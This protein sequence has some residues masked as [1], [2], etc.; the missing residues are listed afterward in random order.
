MLPFILAAKARGNSPEEIIALIVFLAIA[1]LILLL[2]NFN[3][4]V[5][6]VIKNGL[7]HCPLCGRQ[8]SL[9]RDNCRACGYQI[10]TYGKAAAERKRPV[11]ASS[12]LSAN[13]VSDWERLHQDPNDYSA[14]SGLEQAIERE[15]GERLMGPK[16][17]DRDLI[18]HKIILR[19]SRLQYEAHVELYVGHDRHG[20]IITVPT[21]NMRI[22][23]TCPRVVPANVV[24]APW[25]ELLENL[26]KT[27]RWVIKQRNSKSSPLT[28]VPRHGPNPT[29]K[30]EFLDPNAPQKSLPTP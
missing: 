19:R 10:R 18:L 8:V 15:I 9:R 13:W 4:H 23:I 21:H 30:V 24:G 25:D 1:G 6:V 16:K 26:C 17:V 28:Y 27:D 2:Y 22:R 3:T 11:Q 5:S 14:R 7:P 12:L 20:F 29:V